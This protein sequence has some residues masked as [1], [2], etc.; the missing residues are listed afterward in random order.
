MTA[1]GMIEQFRTRSLREHGIG[2]PSTSGA[3]KTVR[4][5]MNHSSWK[6]LCALLFDRLDAQAE[7]AALRQQ[8][9]FETAQ[10][11]RLKLLS[12]GTDLLAQVFL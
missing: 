1:V 9:G 11:R 6:W 3:R 10:S 8:I 5:E 12:D 4:G 2:R 7:G